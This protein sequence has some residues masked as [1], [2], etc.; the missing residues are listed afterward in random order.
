[1]KIYC[2]VFSDFLINYNFL[3]PLKTLLANL[4][5]SWVTSEIINETNEI[6]YVQD[7]GH[8][9]RTQLSLYFLFFFIELESHSRFFA[10]KKAKLLLFKEYYH[11]N[12]KNE[13][14]FGLE[15]HIHK[16]NFY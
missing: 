13:F 7:R 4:L 16:P 9:S 2:F 3:I 1:M 8:V 15:T 14:G 10:F 11:E 12:S 5:T 6:I